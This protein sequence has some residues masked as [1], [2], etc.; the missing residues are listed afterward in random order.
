MKQLVEDWM[1]KHPLKVD[2][3]EDVDSAAEIMNDETIRHLVVTDDGQLAGV[4]SKKDLAT[5]EKIRAKFQG[6]DCLNIKISAGDIMG[7]HPTTITGKATMTEAIRLM[8]EKG[9]H[10]LPVLDEY[11]RLRGI[12]TSTDV[13]KY[14]LV[15]SQRSDFNLS[16]GRLSRGF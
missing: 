5:I 8:N 7:R 10:S 1:T 12:L 14:A 2:K 13:M 3:N 6:L 16:Y 11:E 9:F 15:A 4:I